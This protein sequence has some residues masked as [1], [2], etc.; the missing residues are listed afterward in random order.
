MG[1]AAQE[2]PRNVHDMKLPFLSTMAL[3]AGTSGARAQSASDAPISTDRPGFLFAPTVVPAG[4]L[5][6][7]VGFP[8]WMLQ[9][10]AGVETR[11]WSAPVGVRHGVSET[12]ELR[13][14]LPTWTEVHTESGAS[15]ERDAGLGDSELGVKLA[16][17]PLA[18]GPLALQAALRLPTGAEGFTTDRL[19]GNALLLHGRG[20]SGF[21]LQA[22]A[23]VTYVPAEGAEDQTTGALAALVSHPLGEGR[24]GYVEATALPGL[25][26]AAGQAYL[27][28]GWLWT[29]TERLQLDLSADFGL[30]GDSA[31][32]LVAFGVSWFF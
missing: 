1:A 22:M 9:R 21:W 25:A 19:G 8:T 4:R 32:A 17:A 14:S 2:R 29:P 10:D 3:L 6:L 30:D 7:E 31:D 12:L 13:A 26:H 28:A 15:S 18:G 27:G 20:L 24:V 5:Q 16:L 11:A 23:G